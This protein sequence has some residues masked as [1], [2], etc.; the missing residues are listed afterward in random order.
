VGAVQEAGFATATTVRRARARGGDD[1]YRLPRVQVRE[2]DPLR[3][4]LLK[5]VTPYE[6]FRGRRADERQRRR[7]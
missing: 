3:R 5:L 4:F 2:Q 7:A 1:P 6:D